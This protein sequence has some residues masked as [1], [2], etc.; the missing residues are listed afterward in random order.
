MRNKLFSIVRHFKLTLLVLFVAL[1]AAQTSGAS[2]VGAAQT[3]PARKAELESAATAKRAL[4]ELGTKDFAR[5][6]DARLRVA[7][8]RAVTTLKAVANNTSRSREATLVAQLDRSI[9][10]LKALPQPAGM[11]LQAC[12]KSY[13]T[14]MELCKETGGDCKLCGI[15]QNGCYLVRLAIEMAQEKDP[16]KN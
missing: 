16:S 6:K 15:G 5:V 10:N 4:A 11:S 8:L 13:E 12:D 3:A 9:L 2:G 7:A 1:V 14:C